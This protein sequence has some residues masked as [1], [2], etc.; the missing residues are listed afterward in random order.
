MSTCQAYECTNTI[1][2]TEKGNPRHPTE[3]N[4]KK[5]AVTK[6]A[7]ISQYW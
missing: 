4:N 6:P 2:T 3:N 7:R 5:E 1:V